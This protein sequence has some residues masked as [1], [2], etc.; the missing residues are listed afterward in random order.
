MASAPSWVPVKDHSVV[1]REMER[2][3]VA[4]SSTVHPHFSKANNRFQS[5]FMLIT[6]QPRFV[7]SS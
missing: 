6:T 4:D 1:T 3:A 7:A 2:V 5:F